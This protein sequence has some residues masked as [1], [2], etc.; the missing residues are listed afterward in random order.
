MRAILFLI[1]IVIGI[2]LCNCFNPYVIAVSAFVFILISRGCIVLISTKF[3]YAIRWSVILNYCLLLC[4][5]VT[6]GSASALLNAPRYGRSTFIISGYNP[7]KEYLIEGYVLSH[8][9]K[10]NVEQQQVEI[11]TV[12]ALNERSIVRCRNAKMLLFTPADIQLRQGDVITFRCNLRLTD[13]IAGKDWNGGYTAFVKNKNNL[14]VVGKYVNIRVFAGKL[15]DKI[16]RIIDRSN[17]T[18][19]SRILLKALILADRSGL[20]RKDIAIYRDAGVAHLL[21]V[22]GLHTGILC[23]AILYLTLPLLLFGGRK[24]RY[25]VLI[26]ILWLFTILT[27]MNYSTLRATLMITLAAIAWIYERQHDQLS[28]VCLAASFILIFSPAGLWDIGFQLSFVC[29]A[30][31]AIFTTPLNP[32][33]KREHPLVYKVCESILVTLIATISLAPLTIFYF[34]SHPTSFLITNII[35]LPLMPVYMILGIIE[36]MILLCGYEIIFISEIIDLFTNFIVNFTS[37]FNGRSIK[38]NMSAPALILCLTLLISAATLTRIKYPQRR[39]I[40]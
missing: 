10:A 32:V 17:L 38:I 11:K 37:I 12:T 29:V 30:S 33:C 26:I 18:E 25:V 40:T 20:A 39:E 1:G 8:I 31:L 34:G 13:S 5:A 2:T 9:S 6:I 23:S 27:G 3:P 36:T 16:A 7:D 19:D 28:I 35:L 22:S 15:R 24:L 14:V 21:A 4:I